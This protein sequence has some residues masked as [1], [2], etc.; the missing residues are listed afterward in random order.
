MTRVWLLEEEEEW[1]SRVSPAATQE[2]RS[3]SAS[4]GSMSAPGRGEP[5]ESGGAAG[6]TGPLGDE[7]S[8]LVRT[9]FV[10]L[11]NKRCKDMDR[12]FIHP[13]GKGLV[14]KV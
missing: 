7:L 8:P 6:E 2:V 10:V 5:E 1:S 9:P 11:H 14:I 4:L 3:L 12:Y 13:V